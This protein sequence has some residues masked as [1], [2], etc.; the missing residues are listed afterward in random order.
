VAVSQIK[1]ET[2]LCF[3]EI[4]GMQADRLRMRVRASQSVQDLWLLRSDI[5]QLL[6]QHFN[7]GEASHRI[8]V[9]LP[10]FAGWIPDKQL[11]RI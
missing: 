7:Q 1:L 9:L 6:A 5:H 2:E 3:Q 10:C 4:E 8:N 11:L